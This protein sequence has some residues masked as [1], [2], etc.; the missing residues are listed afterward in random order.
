[1]QSI[2]GKIAWVAGAGT[3]IGRAGA[4]A[5]ARAG[6]TVILSGRRIPQLEAVAKQITDSGGV[7]EI[8][9]L[10]IV[11]VADVTAAVGRIVDT[12]G[13]LDI[14]VN[15]AGLNLPKRRW[16]DITDEGWKTI[17]DVDLNG[18]FYVSHAALNVMRKQRDGLI[19]N[20]SSMAS[21]SIGGVSGIAYTAAKTAL[22]TMSASIN[23]ENCHLGIRACALCPGEVATEILD[24]RPVPPSP[25]DRARMVQE[26]DV[27]ATILFIAQMP[28]HVCL[29]E[30]HI[31]PTWNRG[32]IGAADRNIARD[33]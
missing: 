12:H 31:T 3:G 13:R 16:R 7:A 11:D 15:S 28:P 10:D 5:L 20:V 14:L 18:A 9:P 21:Q 4:V 2:E 33:D 29:N 24:L 6:A 17:I 32:Y 22:N 30:I 1:M 8:E 23:H 25:E 26:E 27:G 19:V